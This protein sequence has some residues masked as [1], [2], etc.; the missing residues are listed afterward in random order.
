VN[1]KNDL[2]AQDDYVMLYTGKDSY[3]KQQTMKY[4]ERHLDENDFVRVH[5][6][7]I[8]RIRK[9]ESIESHGRDTH[10]M[11]LKNGRKIPVSRSGY[12][13]LKEILKND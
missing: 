9:I 6:S 8:V 7:Y 13:R 4:F 3:L 2:E 11:T 10:E 5:R 12:G 1:S